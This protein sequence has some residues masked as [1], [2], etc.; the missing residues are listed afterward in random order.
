MTIHKMTVVY[1]NCKMKQNR[2]S[3]LL[4]AFIFASFLIHCKKQEV[5]T[6][7]ESPDNLEKI[8]LLGKWKLDSR[9][10]NGVSSLSVECC[11]YLHFEPDGIP[12]DWSGSF[13]AIGAGYHT[14]GDFELDTQND[15]INFSFDGSQRIY[16]ILITNTNIV[17]SYLE[18]SDSLVEYWIKSD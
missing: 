5:E 2:T 13:Q 16:S 10:I 4:L 9:E 15:S 3:L 14:T 7:M 12:T 18:N 1:L 11:D 6:H 8:G 17:L